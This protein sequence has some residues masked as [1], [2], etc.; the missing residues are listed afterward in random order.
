MNR[1]I[2]GGRVRDTAPDLVPGATAWRSAGHSVLV[3]LVGF[4]PFAVAALIAM[5]P[6]SGTRP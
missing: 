3:R 2:A 4:V 5:P 1:G 6:R